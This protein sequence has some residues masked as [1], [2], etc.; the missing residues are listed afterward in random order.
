LF[1]LIREVPQPPKLKG[2]THYTFTELDEFEKGVKELRLNQSAVHGYKPRGPKP[3]SGLSNIGKNI[4]KEKYGTVEHETISEPFKP[5]YTM[6]SE[7]S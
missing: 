2:S 7:R 5:A 1:Y 3:A 6:S 4:T